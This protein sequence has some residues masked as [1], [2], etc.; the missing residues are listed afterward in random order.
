MNEPKVAIEVFGGVKIY[1]NATTRSLDKIN[2]RVHSNEFF[3]ILGPSGCGKTTLLR[4]IA[5]FEELTEGQISLFGEKIGHLPANERP[6]NTVF[7]HYALFPHMTVRENIG[8]GLRQLRK[9]PSEIKTATDEVLDL[10]GLGEFADRKP[11]SMSGG[12]LQRVALA[13]ALAP[14]PKVLVLDEP[15]SALDLK[16]RQKMRFE[17][18]RIQEET[19]ITFVF[20]THDQG[21]A[22]A[23]SD[24]IAVMNAGKIQQVGTAQEIYHN[25]V[26]DFVATFIG[27]TNLLAGIVAGTDKSTCNMVCDGSFPV[28]VAKTAPVTTGDRYTV[29]VRPENIVIH[30]IGSDNGTPA[31]VER[32][33]FLGSDMMVDLSV[34][35]TSVMARFHPHIGGEDIP[36]VGQD[37]RIAA[38]PGAGRLLGR[39][40]S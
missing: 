1:P 28:S 17:L 29:S 26:N 22:L 2:L 14:H 27:E 18:K 13:R 31:K 3:T 7:Q 33:T 15:L 30:P 32:C 34:G 4:V 21:E 39:V 35:G 8:F 11:A 25:P 12:Q 5:G 24:R 16:L 10:A 38:S 37:R 23:M 6:I 9:T 36:V 20:V 19:G 40:G